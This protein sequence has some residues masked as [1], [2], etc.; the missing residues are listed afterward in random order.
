V[1]REAFERSFDWIAEH[2]IFEPGEMGAGSY[3][4]AVVSLAA[5]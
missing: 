3:E 1:S 2:G 5:E 4:K